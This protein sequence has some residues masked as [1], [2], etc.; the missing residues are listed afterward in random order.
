MS[1][2]QTCSKC[3]QT[4]LLEQFGS[5]NQGKGRQGSCRECMNAARAAWGLANREKL[6][7]SDAKRRIELP[8]MPR[9]Y[10]DKVRL[11]VKQ[12]GVCLC[13][14]KPIPKL[15]LPK[16]QIDHKI[17]IVKGGPDD[18]GNMAIAHA[19]CNQE[20]K[21]KT[22]EEHWAYRFRKGDDHTKL[23]WHT[24]DVVIEAERYRGDT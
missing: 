4:K 3:H 12:A 16:S 17:P 10:D 9:T 8:R 2:T 22:L 14:A 19:D 20:K 5:T 15:D 18:F 23:N 13:C 24:L 6:I 21:N 1:G 11:W 7:A